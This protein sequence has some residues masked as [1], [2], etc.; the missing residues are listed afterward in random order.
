MQT[1][2]PN[3]RKKCLFDQTNPWRP[4]CCERCKLID[5][6]DWI[7]EN[8]SIPGEPSTPPDE[9]GLSAEELN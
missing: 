6:G 5:M 7:S 9:D 2:C 3:C 1:S 8:H 4:F